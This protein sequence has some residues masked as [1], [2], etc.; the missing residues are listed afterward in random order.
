MATIEALQNQIQ[1]LRTNFEE[2][3][4]SN[5]ELTSKLTDADELKRYQEA[6]IARRSDLNSAITWLREANRSAEE[7]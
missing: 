1:D 6:L 4:T 2:F 7:Q 5:A 3:R